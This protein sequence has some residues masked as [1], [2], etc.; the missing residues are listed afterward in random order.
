MTTEQFEKQMFGA[1]MKAQITNKNDVLCGK[2][3]PIKEVNFYENLIGLKDFDNYGETIWKRC[4]NVEI[5]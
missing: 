5:V 2:T 3:Y 1:G 4:E